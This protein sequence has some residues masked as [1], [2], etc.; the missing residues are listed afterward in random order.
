MN[1]SK[2]NR[3]TEAANRRKEILSEG[4]K[5]FETS[6]FQEGT[7]QI[8]HKTNTVASH[9]LE[10]TDTAVKI[11]DF[12]EEK[13]IYVNKE[14]LI[15]C[16]LCHDL[17]IIGRD[18]K[19]ANTLD[20]WL[21]HPKDSVEIAEKLYPGISDHTKRVISRH[22]WPATPMWPTSREGWILDLA[23]TI[24]SLKDFFHP[25]HEHVLGD[26]PIDRLFSN[27][28]GIPVTPSQRQAAV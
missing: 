7:H 4:Q 2:I 23:D 17:G 27:M 12:L 20:C 18:E 14:E 6:E 3:K 1:N 5:I 25:N 15:F 24:C 13:G 19:F 21:S 11:S 10:V 22:M 26:E 8:H 16:C 9:T 28:E